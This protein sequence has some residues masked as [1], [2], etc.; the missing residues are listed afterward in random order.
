MIVIQI[1]RAVVPPARPSRSLS[2]DRVLRE[3][4]EALLVRRWGPDVEPVAIDTQADQ[5]MLLPESVQCI[6]ELEL[7][8]VPDVVR[9]VLLQVPEYLRPE[10]VLSKDGQE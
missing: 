3:Y 9:D 4:I 10:H 8:L 7:A 5:S 6:R 1:Q 2:S